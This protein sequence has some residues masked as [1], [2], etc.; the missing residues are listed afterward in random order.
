MVYIKGI[1]DLGFVLSWYS[2]F[3][4][5]VSKNIG[6]KVLHQASQFG[7]FS[8]CN[9]G[10]YKFSIFALNTSFPYSI[11]NDPPCQETSLLED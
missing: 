6:R 3:I 9:A 4:K 8:N 1:W 11:P 10:V 5:T 2:V 7:G